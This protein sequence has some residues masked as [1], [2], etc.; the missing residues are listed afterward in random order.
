MHADDDQ[1]T[2][3]YD[4]PHN[5]DAPRKF[6]VGE[7]DCPVAEDSGGRLIRLAAYND[8]KDRDSDRVVAS[9]VS[10]LEGNPSCAGPNRGRGS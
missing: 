3:H 10:A 2:I 5:S 6:S 9:L 7:A 1:P 8:P 4:R